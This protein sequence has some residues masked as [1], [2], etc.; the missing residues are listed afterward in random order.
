MEEKTKL[1]YRIYTSSVFN[2]QKGS[3]SGPG[4]DM[5]KGAHSMMGGTRNPHRDIE[6]IKTR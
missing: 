2:N 4:W 5:G 6:L 1:K 3:E